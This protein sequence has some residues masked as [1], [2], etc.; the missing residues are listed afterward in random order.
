MA[1]NQETTK[2]TWLSS[3]EIKKQLKISDCQLMHKRVA[4]QLEF[5]KEGRRFLYL[6]PL[7]KAAD[8]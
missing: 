7:K 3:A 4:G 2:Q 1:E 5:K 6:L 8:E